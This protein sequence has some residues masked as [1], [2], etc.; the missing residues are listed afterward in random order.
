M[1]NDSFLIP[2]AV[3]IFIMLIFILFRY[4]KPLRSQADFIISLLNKLSEKYEG[5]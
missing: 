1:M 5:K 2:I 4:V 3:T